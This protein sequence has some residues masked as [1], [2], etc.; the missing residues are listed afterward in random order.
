LKLR[1]DRDDYPFLINRRHVIALAQ[2]REHL[3]A[4]LDTTRAG[5]SFE[6]VTFDVQQATRGL[7]E[8]TGETTPNDVLNKIFADFC[9]GK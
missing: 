8:I 2:A 3:Q 4:A 5:E 1:S 7:G 9:V 6:F